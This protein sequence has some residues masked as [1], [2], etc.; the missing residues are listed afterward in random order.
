MHPRILRE[1]PIC[2]V[3]LCVTQT[4]LP[5]APFRFLACVMTA[6]YPLIGTSVHSPG[7]TL[8]QRLSSPIRN[9]QGTP[10]LQARCDA[11]G[12]VEV[13]HIMTGP[14]RGCCLG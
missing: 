2:A 10:K 4:S 13:Y 11:R 8:D 9:L 7:S 5:F 12:G 6:N 1:W 14:R 3:S